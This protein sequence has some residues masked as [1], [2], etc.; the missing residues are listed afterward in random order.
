[1]TITRKMITAFKYIN[2]HACQSQL[3]SD[4]RTRKSSTNNA[5]FFH[6]NNLNILK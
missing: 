3:T 6:V 5:N 2:G 4:D 1:M